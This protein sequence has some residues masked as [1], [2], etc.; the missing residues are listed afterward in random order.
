MI[1]LPVFPA[2]LQ[3]ESLFRFENLVHFSTT[4]SEGFSSGTFES[5]NLSYFSGDRKTC[6]DRNRQ[7]LCQSLSLKEDAFYVAHQVHGTEIACIDQEFLQL[8]KEQQMNLLDGKDAL[9][10]DL[11]NVTIAVS[12]ADCVPVL[13]YAEDKQVI[14]AVHAGWR[15]T[16][17][18][19]VE[20]TIQQ[21][22]D[23]YQCSPSRIHAAIGP[24]ISP[25]AFEVGDEVLIAFQDAGFNLL[26]L[27][28]I[29]PET[30][31]HHIDLWEANRQQLA[32]IGLPPCQ[33]E[34]SGICTYTHSDRF[35]SARKLGIHSGRM[36]TGECLV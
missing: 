7:L 16:C 8:S 17:R 31:K 6:V 32:E 34:I 10:T 9:L 27:S 24:S 26:S 13:L 5:F 12:T 23:R 22:I 4:R 29:H 35:F 18:R 2:V 20:K 28:H 30:G 1:P 14:G 15:G 11:K 25:Q 21:M 19:I 3:F 36:L 33:I